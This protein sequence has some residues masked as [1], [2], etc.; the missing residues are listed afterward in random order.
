MARMEL[1]FVTL[2]FELKKTLKIYVL[3]EREYQ[4]VS[5]SNPFVVEFFLSWPSTD[6][7]KFILTVLS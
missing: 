5:S 4:F 6:I 3:Q 7:T 2:W 1:N